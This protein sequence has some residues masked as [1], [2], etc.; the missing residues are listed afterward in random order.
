MDRHCEHFLQL[1]LCLG[2]RLILCAVAV[3]EG[4]DFKLALCDST[5]LIGEK[6]VQGTCCFDTVYLADKD[7]VL[8]HL[9]HVLGGYNSYHKGKSLGNS[10][11]DDDYRKDNSV[12][13]VCYK[14]LDKIGVGEVNSCS[15][16]FKEYS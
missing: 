6:N 9:A 12:K 3:N 11:Y 13:N 10:H 5:C 2:N 14:R 15:A 8:E 4:Y 16:A 7:I 1:I